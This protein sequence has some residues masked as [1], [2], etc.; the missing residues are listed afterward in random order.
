MRQCLNP[1]FSGRGFRRV[2]IDTS[3]IGGA[4]A[5]LILVLVEEGLGEHMKL[6]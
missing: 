4:A 3:L 6:V 5:V 2:I 1:C